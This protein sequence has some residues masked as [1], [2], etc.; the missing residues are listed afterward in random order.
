MK[1][2]LTLHANIRQQLQSQLATVQA[3][4]AFDLRVV[5]TKGPMV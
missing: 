3:D 5:A 2:R 1:Y 4:E